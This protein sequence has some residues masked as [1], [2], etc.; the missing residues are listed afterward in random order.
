M[1]V[2]LPLSEL[3]IIPLFSVS[4][5]EFF[6]PCWTRYYLSRIQVVSRLAEFCSVLRL[7][8]SI[9]SCIP[10]VSHGTVCW[11]I[12]ACIMPVWLCVV[13]CQFRSNTEWR[14]RSNVWIALGDDNGRCVTVCDTCYWTFLLPISRRWVTSFAETKV[15]YFRFEAKVLTHVS[16]RPSDLVGNSQKKFNIFTDFIR[17]LI[18]S[19]CLPL[20]FVLSV[21]GGYYT[22][23][24]YDVVRGVFV[25]FT[26]V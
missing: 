1:A 19:T 3:I 18:N 21:R 9:L 22:A 11:C 20:F 7:C 12:F 17:R 10:H 23:L 16:D 26:F 13:V 5:M 2:R 4:V 15:L 14:L 8:H 25:L 24:S 6:T